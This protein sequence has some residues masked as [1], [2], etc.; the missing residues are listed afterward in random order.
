MIEVEVPKK[1]I[2]K[3]LADLHLYR[4]SGVTVMALQSKGQGSRIPRGDTVL[5]EGDQLIL[6]GPK[7]NLD[8]LDVS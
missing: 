8:E 2:G 5:K 1:W 4:E 6:G 3:T 7:R